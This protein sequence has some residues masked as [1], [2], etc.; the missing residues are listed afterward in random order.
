MDLTTKTFTAVT[1]LAFAMNVAGFL[2]AYALH[3]DL[4]TD[5]IGSATFIATA[6][7]S[8]FLNDNNSANGGTTRPAIMTAL[9]CVARLELAL[10]L[11]YRVIKRGKDARFDRIRGSCVGFGFFWFFQFLWAWSVSFPVY[12]VNSDLVNPPLGAADGVGIA[13]WAFGFLLQ[14]TADF[15][16]DA[17]R[18]N[19][20]NDGKVCNKGVWAWSRHPNFAGE[21]IMWWG[22]LVMGIPVY[23]NSLRTPTGWGWASLMSPLMTM[24]ILMFGSGI[25]TAE[26][27]NQKRYLKT[28]FSRRAYLKYRAQTSP[29]LPCPPS[30]YGLLPLFVK[31][32]VCCEFKVYEMDWS[33]CGE[34][35]PADEATVQG[36]LAAAARDS[37]TTESPISSSN[38]S[39]SKAIMSA[40]ADVK[41]HL[42]SPLVSETEKETDQGYQAAAATSSS[43]SSSSSE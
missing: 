18:S 42:T 38:S 13:L 30:I 15:Q 22:M 31:R 3:I 40:D 36:A 6:L 11:L 33:Y 34:P 2:I 17:F 20:A 10:Y 4:V 16:K 29:L 43:S 12:F 21:I 26:G 19:K 5:F 32:L 25:P 27:V 9:L 24:L 8:F 35:V 23:S 14:V 28:L 37:N 1:V 7:L 41:T 39:G